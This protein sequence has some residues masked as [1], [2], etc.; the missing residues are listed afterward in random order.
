MNSETQIP[1]LARA[2]L[3]EAK[4]ARLSRR[5]LVIA[6]VVGVVVVG[7]LSVRWLAAGTESTD[8]AHVA[9]DMVPVATA[10]PV[11]SSAYPWPTTRP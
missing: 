10:L 11:P 4:K 3:V 2:Q 9:T 6:A 8:D 1:A 7:G 5:Y